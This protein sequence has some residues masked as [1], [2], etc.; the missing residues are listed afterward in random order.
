[1]CH[2]KQRVDERCHR[3]SPWNNEHADDEEH[4]DNWRQPPL[5]VVPQEVD[6]LGEQSGTFPTRLLR[7]GRAIE[8]SDAPGTLPVLSVLQDSAEDPVR[9]LSRVRA[10]RRPSSACVDHDLY[11]LASIDADRKLQR[12]Y[13][14]RV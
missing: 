1:M 10:A 8:E 11:G 3:G 12:T 2:Q 6:Q 4:A 14:A 9:Q 13:L 5:L 7:E